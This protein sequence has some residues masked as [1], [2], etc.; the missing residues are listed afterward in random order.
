MKFPRRVCRTRDITAPVDECC[1][2]LLQPIHAVEDERI[3]EAIVGPVMGGE[4][5]EGEAVVVVVPA[6][7][8][9]EGAGADRDVGVLPQCPLAGSGVA[10]GGIWAAQ[11]VGVSLDEAGFAADVAGV[12]ISA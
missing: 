11:E 6:R 3:E 2:D 7:I 9:A 10:D 5:G 4:P 1:W 12:A 8:A